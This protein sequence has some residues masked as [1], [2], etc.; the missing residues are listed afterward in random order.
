MCSRFRFMAEE[1][2]PV[3]GRIELVSLNATKTTLTSPPPPELENNRRTLNIRLLSEAISSLIL[4]SV[5]FRTHLYILIGYGFEYSSGIA[6]NSFW[7]LTK[8]LT[9]VAT[10]SIIEGNCHLEWWGV[11]ASIIEIITSFSMLGL[12]PIEGVFFFFLRIFYS[13]FVSFQSSLV[14]YFFLS[15]FLI[16]ISILRLLLFLARAGLFS[17]ALFPFSPFPTFE[18]TT[19]IVPELFLYTCGVSVVL[20]FI[21]TW[22]RRHLEFMNPAPYFF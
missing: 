2:A 8:N 20:D 10:L 4:L 5:R 3:T 9:R 15:F 19:K 21:T 1:T 6:L 18:A 16:F 14:L 7:L 13:L 11:I 22:Q 12:G 17:S